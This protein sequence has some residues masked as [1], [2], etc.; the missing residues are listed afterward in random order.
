MVKEFRDFVLRG[1][2]VDLAIAV[3]IGTAFATVV[4]SFT[5]NILMNIIALF[6][7]Q[8]DFSS[9][10]FSLGDTVFT[11]GAFLTD[12]VSFV[13]LAAIVFFFVVKPI[14]LFLSRMKKEEA[15]KAPPP[16]APMSPAAERLLEELRLALKDIQAKN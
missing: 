10:D 9:L 7:G 1:N 11:Y 15:A 12:V 16:P 2:V 3:M 4:K 8:P 13:I 14:N 5:D 6:G